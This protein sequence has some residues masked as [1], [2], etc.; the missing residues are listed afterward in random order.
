[1]KLT[2]ALSVL[3]LLSINAVAQVSLY[4]D[5][6][7]TG[8]KR[9]VTYTPGICASVPAII[10]EKV[11]SIKIPSGTSCVLWADP[12][13]PDGVSSI[14][15]VDEGNGFQIADFGRE[16]SIDDA[17]SSFRCGMSSGPAV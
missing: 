16:T 2:I 1:M 13:C 15:V 8:T 7:F 4:A 12:G 10:D 6:N 3:S 17:M 9:T 11:S 14:A 5:P